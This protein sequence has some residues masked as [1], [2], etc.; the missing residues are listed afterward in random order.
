MTR[1]ILNMARQAVID[2]KRAADLAHR[3]GVH[4]KKLGM[5]DSLSTLC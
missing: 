2:T 5:F 3:D 4:A 1:L